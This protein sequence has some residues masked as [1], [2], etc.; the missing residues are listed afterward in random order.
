MTPQYQLH[1]DHLVRVQA[2]NCEGLEFVPDTF[3]EVARSDPMDLRHALLQFMIAATPDSKTLN[4]ILS[5]YDSVLEKMTTS[6]PGLFAPTGDENVVFVDNVPDTVNPVKAKMAYIQVPT[7]D[8]KS[9]ELSLVWKFEVEMQDNWYEASVAMAAPHRIIS[10]VDWASDAYLRP[11]PKPEEPE[12]TAQYLGYAWGVNDPECGERSVLKQND[13]L[14]ASPVGWHSLPYSE[15][16][17]YDGVAIKAKSFFRNTT[18]T[19]GNNVRSDSL[20]S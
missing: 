3:A 18:T 11:V 7:K 12:T 19:W 10:V 1:A 2:D 5:D 15:D 16:P 17:T 6:Q 9:T 13:D 20:T 8:G 4:N 14:L